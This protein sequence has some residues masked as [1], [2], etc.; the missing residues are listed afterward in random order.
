MTKLKVTFEE[1]CFDN[2]DD[3]TEEE[4]QEFI[5]DLTDALESGEFFENSVPVEELPPEEQEEI[6][7]LLTR[8]KNTRH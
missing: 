2:L 1:G 6:M 7:E 5:L 4:M 8:K 3:L